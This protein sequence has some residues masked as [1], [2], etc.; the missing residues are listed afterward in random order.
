MSQTPPE[1]GF[2]DWIIKFD[3]VTGN[4]DKERKGPKEK[5]VKKELKIRCL[6]N[7]IMINHAPVSKY[8]VENS[9]GSHPANDENLVMTEPYLSE[10]V[11]IVAVDKRHVRQKI[12]AI[13]KKAP[14]RLELWD[15]FG[16]L[17]F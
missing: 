7:K 5:P 9:W 6:K 11:Y 13:Q 10:Y 16:Y 4:R 12:A 1:E 17:L 15:P 2:E 3:S 8:L 14:T